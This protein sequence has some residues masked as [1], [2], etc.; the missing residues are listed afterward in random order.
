M[1][2]NPAKHL[3]HCWKYCG[4]AGL[5]EAMNIP[6]ALLPP[7]LLAHMVPELSLE[8]PSIAQIADLPATAK[9]LLFHQW[10]SGGGRRTNNA[11]IFLNL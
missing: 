11:C 2:N 7:A 10:A 1:Q 3:P 8:P 6:G 5:S 9:N 4:S